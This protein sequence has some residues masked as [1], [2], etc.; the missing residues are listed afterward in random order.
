LFIINYKIVES[1]SALLI[2]ELNM[3]VRTKSCIADTVQEIKNSLWSFQEAKFSK[4]NREAN[5]GVDGLGIVR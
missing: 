4:V 1:D 3:N 5:K 2:N